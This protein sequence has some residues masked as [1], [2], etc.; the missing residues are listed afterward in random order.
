VSALHWAEFLLR[1]QPAGGALAL[2]HQQIAAELG[3]SREVVSRILADF[4]GS[5]LVQVTRGS[6]TVLERAG[7]AR[8]AT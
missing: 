2:T 7:L 6:V 3:T 1:Q 4:S 5:G 8:R